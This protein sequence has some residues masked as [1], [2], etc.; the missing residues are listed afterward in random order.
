ML[1]RCYENVNSF[2][3]DYTWDTLV[4]SFSL[5]KYKRDPISLDEF[6]V[7]IKF[8]SWAFQVRFFFKR[9]SMEYVKFVWKVGVHVFE[10]LHWSILDVTY[11]FLGGFPDHFIN[12]LH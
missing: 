12:S 7:Y 2:V 10:F 8:W 9:Q 1:Q 4:A 6:Y 3:S 11:I 5:L